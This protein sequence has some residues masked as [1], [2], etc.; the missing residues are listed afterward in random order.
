LVVCEA[1]RAERFVEYLHIEAGSGASGG[2]HAAL[3]F[4]DTTYHY[5]YAEPGIIESAAEANDSFDYAYRGLGNRSIHASRIVVEDDVYDALAEAFERRH[6]TQQKQL[7]VLDAAVNDQA[8]IAILREQRCGSETDPAIAR[9]VYEIREVREIRLHAA[10]YFSSASRSESGTRSV[11]SIAGPATAL[12][13]TPIAELGAEVEREHGAGYLAGRKRAV[14]DEI[15]RLAFAPATASGI[16]FATIPPRS[17][18]FAERYETLALASAA[19]DILLNER[20]PIPNAYRSIDDSARPLTQS[21]LATLIA[22][23]A[24]LRSSLLKLVTSRRRDWGYPMLVGMARLVALDASLRSGRLVIPDSLD[25]A[26]AWVSVETLLADPPVVRALLQERRGTFE[27]ARDELFA[28]PATNEAA[29]SRFEVAASAVIDLEHAVL[30]GD[31]VVRAYATTMLPSRSAEP[32]STFPVPAAACDVL[33]QWVDLAAAATASI[34]DRLREVYRYNVTSRNC[35]TELFRTMEAA[36]SSFDLEAQPTVDAGLGFVPFISAARVN[37]TY[38]IDERSTLPSYRKYWLSR[39]SEA[40]GGLRVALRESNTLTSTLRHPDD[41]DDVFLFYTDDTVALRPL[42]GAINAGVG[43]GASLLGLAM[44]PFD[45][46]E[47][48]TTGVRSVVF[49]LPELVFVNLRKGKNS[50]LPWAWMA[51]SED[52]P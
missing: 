23:N 27:Q 10:G 33:D 47:R 16:A 7:E 2:G 21:D 22:R 15:A 34:R 3:R 9:Q 19:L 11:P 38:P 29:W 49:S 14:E 42:Y 32:D 20:T 24:D 8:L 6:I 36:S 43:A 26:A 17:V 35:V 12:R 41:R 51:G 40:R 31:G 5:V 4:A 13:R 37:Q 25:D 46:G 18:G 48:L 30:R 45:R 52:P 50:V 39:L 1:A 28:A 44:L